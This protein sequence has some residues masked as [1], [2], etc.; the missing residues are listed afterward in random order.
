MTI[1]E[2]I[3]YNQSL[4]KERIWQKKPQNQFSDNPVLLFL[5]TGERK[6]SSPTI[7]A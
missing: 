4:M 5:L 3:F 1:S 2:L 7:K 6:N